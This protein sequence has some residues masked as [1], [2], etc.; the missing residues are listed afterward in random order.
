MTPEQIIAQLSTL[1]ELYGGAVLCVAFP[2]QTGFL[3]SREDS[4]LE[5]LNQLLAQGATPLAFLFQ[6]HDGQKLEI[7]AMPLKT[8]ENAAGI[9]GY[10]ETIAEWYRGLLA[11]D[12][13]M[14]RP[15]VN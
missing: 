5:V 14:P 6:R 4:K 12:G 2:D 1:G 15:V 10:L 7:V 13:L 11:E 3:F 8:V 9:D